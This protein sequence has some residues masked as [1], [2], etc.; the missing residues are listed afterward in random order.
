MSVAGLLLTSLGLF[1]APS[2]MPNTTR[3]EAVTLF[4]PPDTPIPSPDPDSVADVL[5]QDLSLIHI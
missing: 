2:P 1:V 5:V 3:E 4:E